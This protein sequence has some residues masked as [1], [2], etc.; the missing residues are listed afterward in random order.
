MKSIENLKLEKLDS[1]GLLRMAQVTWAYFLEK[2]E[3]S[4]ESEEMLAEPFGR[5]ESDLHELERVVILS[6]Q[7]TPEV[8]SPELREEALDKARKEII[9]DYRSLINAHEATAGDDR[10][11]ISLLT[12]AY[13]NIVSLSAHIRS[14]PSGE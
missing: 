13:D 1:N 11:L 10:H 12:L 2:R 4:Q 9:A 14:F 5:F 7:P 6:S 3:A 8:L